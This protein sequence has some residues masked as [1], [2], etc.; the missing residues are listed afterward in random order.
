MD[1]VMLDLSKAFDLVPQNGLIHKI[2]GYGIGSDLL[3]WF[4]DFLKERK[5]RVALEDS[6]SD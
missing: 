2:K 3:E 1:E 6:L 4:G 5:Q